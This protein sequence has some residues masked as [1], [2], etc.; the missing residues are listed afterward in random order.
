MAILIRA[1][2]LYVFLGTLT[3]SS[4]NREIDSLHRLATKAGGRAQAD[5]YL[6]AATASR[7]IQADTCLYFAGQALAISQKE[8]YPIG[9]MT[10]YIMMGRAM[11]TKGSY[12]LAQKFYTT[13]ETQARKAVNDSLTARA[14]MGSAS[15]FWHLGKH[16]EALELNLAAIRLAEKN[17]LPVDV[18]N[19]KV[20]IAMIYQSQEKVPLAEKYVRE[21][22]EILRDQS[23]P[24]QRL[25]A[26][27]TLANI[28][29]MQGKITDAMDIDK[30]GLTLSEQS[31]NQFFKSMFYDNM[32][33]CYLFGDPPD[34]NRSLQYFRLSFSIDSSF[35]N[36]KQMSDSYRNMGTVFMTQKKY[37]EAIPFLIRS[38]ELARSAGF[39][40]GEQ[41]TSQV[42]ST[43]YNLSG[44]DPLA[45]E[46]LKNSNRLKDSLVNASREA[47]IAEL[48]A[49]YETEKQKQ[50]IELQETQLSR[51][52]YII[53]G[54]LI[55]ALLAGLL[56]YSLYRRYQLKQQSRLQQEIMNQQELATR[57]VIQAEE[58]ER[59]RIARD[60]H[61]GVGQMMSAAKMNLSAFEAE[62]QF[63]N[64]DQRLSFEKIV[65]LVDESCKEIREVSHNMV[66]NALLKHSLSAAV[67]D[68]LDKIDQKALRIHLYTEGLDKRLDSSVETVLYRVIQECVNNVIKHANASSL[69]ISIIRDNDGISATIEDNG[70]GFDA[71]AKEHADGIGL[72][73]IQARIGYLK[74]TIDLDSA[75]GR[76]TMIGLHVPVAGAS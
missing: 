19:A 32:A 14:L 44:N 38:I 62:Q 64:P 31:G 4:Q 24:T 75:P 9:E 46:T 48:Q 17:N 45:Y 73:N 68:F 65:G 16:A 20:G 28:Y 53:T 10:S 27:H 58:K 1:T 18:A 11:A 25:N 43:A 30:E 61:D 7:N 8:K 6:Q 54:T 50:T 15:C 41:E 72:K 69:D 67:R 71:A 2:L 47:K 5:L 57:A 39:L 49:F 23:A 70:T 51:K 12:I 26:L 42:L 21:A 36:A 66:P 60:L 29:G 55:T 52:N 34:F 35:G 74:G 63:G 56:G 76:G 22:L 40:Q 3:A 33:N 37:T 13:A 59:E